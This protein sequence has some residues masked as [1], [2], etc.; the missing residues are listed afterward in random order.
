M[1]MVQ[2]YLH[3]CEA[4]LRGGAFTMF[5]ERKR[6]REFRGMDDHRSRRLLTLRLGR[7]FVVVLRRFPI[8]VRF[9]SAR[10]FILGRRFFGFAGF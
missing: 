10:F 3:N 2:G 4:A 8:A 9:C 6:G 5:F 1:K 7:F